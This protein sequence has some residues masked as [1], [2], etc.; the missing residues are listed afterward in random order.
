MKKKTNKLGSGR[1]KSNFPTIMLLVIVATLSFLLVTV[2]NRGSKNSPSSPARKDVTSFPVKKDIVTTGVTRILSA[3][4]MQQGSRMVNYIIKTHPDARVR[5]S[6]YHLIKSRKVRLE[7]I[8]DSVSDQ[9]AVT[10][11]DV[12]PGYDYAIPILRV[13]H[14]CMVNPRKA[15]IDK[16]AIYL[17]EFVHINELLTG[18]VPPEV[19][20]PEVAESM[21]PEIAREL[22]RTELRAYLE[23]CKFY[24]L[25]GGGN[26][27][28]FV[29]FQEGGIQGMA[30]YVV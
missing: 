5:D 15:D 25:H 28:A 30:Q 7:M 26:H 13:N 17:H 11:L 12:L 9:C 23:M 16:Q 29:L 10:G 24:A 20:G 21:T 3:E 19:Y 27:A 6:L 4:E 8:Y 22:L 14:L 2:V 18:V 1:K